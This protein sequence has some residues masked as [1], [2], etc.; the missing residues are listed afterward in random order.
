[1]NTSTTLACLWC[2]EAVHDDGLDHTV[3]AN[4]LPIHHE[5]L[6][7]MTAGSVAHQAK[8]CRCFGGRDSEELHGLTVRERAFLAAALFNFRQGRAATRSDPLRVR[9]ALHIIDLDVAAFARHAASKLHQLDACNSM[10]GSLSMLAM[11]RG[12]AGVDSPLRTLRQMIGA[13]LLGYLSWICR[14]TKRA[15]NGA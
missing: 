12:E 8:R 4:G 10:S 5:C 6:T 14:P 2:D 3:L 13:G 15:D 1:M 11:Q 7:R 9:P